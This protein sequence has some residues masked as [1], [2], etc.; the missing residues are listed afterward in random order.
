MQVKEKIAFFIPSTVT[1]M[2]D[3][4][5]PMGKLNGA[6]DKDRVIVQLTKW[7]KA[8]RKPE[9]RSLKN[10]YSRTGE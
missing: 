2:P 10:I 8:S 4:F 7:E 3:I 6:K 1:P 9:R 5:I